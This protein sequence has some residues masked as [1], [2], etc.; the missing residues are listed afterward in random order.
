MEETYDDFYS[1]YEEEIDYKELLF[2][3]LIRLPWFVVSLLV[4]MAAAFVYLRYQE[5]VYS[6]SS[7]VLIKEEEKKNANDLQT[8]MQ[9]FGFLSMTSRFDNEVIILNSRTLVKKVISQL[10]LYINLS[11]SRPFQYALSLYR[12]SPIRV[13]M[14]AEEA[15][16]LEGVVSLE[17]DCHPDGS[18]TLSGTYELDKEECEIE[19]HFPKLPIVL[20]LPV[21]TI[22]ISREIGQLHGQGDFT[23]TRHFNAVIRNPESVATAYTSSLS[24]EPISKQSTI[25]TITLNDYNIQR[26]IDFTNT[27][28][29]LYNEDTNTEKNEVA[30]KSAEFIEERIHIIH[31]ELGSTESE[32]A[33]F[34]QRSGL[35]NLTND[36]LLS[37]EENLKYE[38]QYTN[39]LNQLSLVT[40]LRDYIS[41]PSNEGEVI[42]TNVGLEDTRL[43]AILEQ[44]NSLVL[45]RK[46]LLRTSSES[47]PAVVT[48]NGS[49]EAMRQNVLTTVGS[50]L[51]GLQMTREN[52]NRQLRKYEGRVSKAPK[53]EQE[54]INISRQQEIKATLYTM[55]LEKREENAI[56]LAA[57]ANN[58]RIIEEPMSTG[59]VSPDLKIVILMVIVAGIGIP[60]FI[61]YMVN[62]LKYRIEGRVDVERITR[63][64]IIGDIPLCNAGKEK[65]GEFTDIVVREGSNDMMAEAFRSVRTNLLFILGEPHRK[66]VL[67]TSTM[68]GEGKTFISVN[69]AVSLALLGKKVILL[70]LDIRKPR[71]SKLFSHSIR[72]KG[73]SQYLAAP[74]STDWRTLVQ[75]SGILPHLHLMLGGAVPPNPTELLARK[76]LDD[77][78]EQLRGEY[79]YIVFDTAPIGMITDTQ[80]I[81]RVADASVYVCRADYTHKNDFRLINELKANQRLPNLCT[82][83]NAFDTTQRK[84]GYYYSYGS[85]G[86]HYGY[87]KY[88]KYYLYGPKYGYGYGYGT[89]KAAE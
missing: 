44:Y 15:T 46:H 30:Q 66:V 78:V 83:I 57:T 67:V 17:I 42:P 69:L 11:E 55:L 56:T 86:R 48:L 24:V 10:G 47:N 50:V 18:V 38:Q 77:L 87:G 53:Q 76:S 68:N 21:G 81:A 14:T 80:I 52:I 1:E 88:G 51:S 45:E 7:S 25:A 89:E 5:P 12:N 6:V 29:D 8:A 62:L 65:E 84:Y 26:A 35:T 41:L 54:F 63:I 82:V 23:E 75:P 39:T 4:C 85:Y 28:I 33:D 74:Q 19:K 32:L 59:L 20:P 22:H 43:S 79:D 16:K 34:K 36:A 71:L 61:I 40:Y 2:H 64:P 3:C 58:C 31:G 9:D 73:I 27:L 70:G 60:L 49:I 37:L 72:G 13:F